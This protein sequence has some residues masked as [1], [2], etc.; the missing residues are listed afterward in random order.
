MRSDGTYRK[1]IKIRAG[2]K[3]ADMVQKYVIP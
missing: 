1:D 3:N 2:Y